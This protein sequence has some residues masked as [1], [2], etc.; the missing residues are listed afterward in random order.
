MEIGWAVLGQ[1]IVGCVTAIATV[2]LAMLT[3]RL[4]R[5]T[6]ALARAKPVPMIVVTF[7]LSPTG[8]PALDVLVTNSGQAVAFDVEIQ[9]S[10]PISFIGPENYSPPAL[11][12]FASSIMRP[13]QRIRW[14]GI[15]SSDIAGKKFLVGAAW[16]IRPNGTKAKLEYDLSGDVNAGGWVERGLHTIA[17][18]VKKMRVL[19]EKAR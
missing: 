16:A 9:I 4:A 7:E 5:A 12:Q 11:S 6:E 3:F 18:E 17:E 15:R 14:G 19:M 13:G 2:V 8:Q 1:I 10:P